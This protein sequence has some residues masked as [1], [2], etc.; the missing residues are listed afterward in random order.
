MREGFWR[1]RRVLVTGCTGLLGSWLSARLV[2]L[3]ADVVGLIRDEVVGSHLSRSG[4]DHR[5]TRVRGSVTS[6]KTVERALNEYE[7]DTCFHLAA[8]TIVTIANRSPLSTFES[9]IKGT[10]TVLEAARRARTVERLVVAS[11]DKAY[12]ASPQL[13]YS[14]ETPLLGRYPYDVSKTC[15][16]HLAQSYARTYRVPLAITRCGNLYGGG[17]L[18]FNRVVPGTARAILLDEDPVIRSDGTPLR[19]Y[20]YVEDAVAA[21]LT[22]AER[23][24][25]EAVPGEAFNFS[26][27]QP[28][29]VREVVERLI[30]ISGRTHL[31]P[32]I[33]GQSVPEGEIAHQYLSAAK[34]KRVLGWQA[35]WAM[36]DALAKTLAWYEAYL[37]DRKAS[38]G[39]R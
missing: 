8:Q 18:N 27:E 29:S 3:G 20:L 7:I 34:A 15:A 36:D 25:D 35:S 14:E 26:A 19:D 32:R 6:F 24:L 10:W 30:A 12:G 37:A 31:K 9:N 21:C 5:I 39:R 28:R 1:G 16:D 22:L 17:D 11:S 38:C 23:L 33:L 2:E 4:T 13:P